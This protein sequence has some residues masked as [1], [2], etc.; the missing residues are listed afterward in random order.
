VGVGKE[1]CRDSSQIFTLKAG[2]AETFQKQM[3]SPI[4]V[5]SY[6]WLSRPRVPCYTKMHSLMFEGS[7]GIKAGG[8]WGEIS[9]S[10]QCLKGHS[11]D[12]DLSVCL[13]EDFLLPFQ[14][15]FLSAAV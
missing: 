1:G 12:L 9:L 11:G 15:F 10:S 14:I 2:A 13:T 3:E 8:P 6:L 4:L 7:L 5:L